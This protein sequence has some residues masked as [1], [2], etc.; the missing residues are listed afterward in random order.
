MKVSRGSIG[1]IVA[2]PF[3]ARQVPERVAI[4]YAI[5][6][7]RPIVLGGD[8]PKVQRFILDDIGTVVISEPQNRIRQAIFLFGVVAICGTTSILVARRAI[9]E[10]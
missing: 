1:Q 8:S 6:I 3:P 2:A 10:I 4:L 5:E 7:Q 9:A